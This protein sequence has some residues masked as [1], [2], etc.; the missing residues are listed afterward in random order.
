M[1]D[2]E[3]R[4]WQALK[5]VKFPGMSRDIVSFGFVEA[6]ATEGGRATVT[7]Q[8]TTHNEEAV[9]QVRDD[10]ERA[11]AGVD[12][13]ESAQV[14][15]K[16][17]RPPTPGGGAQRAVSQDAQL[18]SNV[19]HVVAV[20]SGKGGV[21]KSTVAANLAVS[22][23]KAG[24]RVG[25]L[26]ADIYGPSMPMMFGIT[27]RPRIEANRVIPFER[28]GVKVMSLGFVVDTDTP[29]IW[30]GPMVMKALEQLMGD[31]EWGELDYMIVDLPPGTGDAQLTITQK[32]PLSGAVVVTTPQDVALIDA[33]KGLA[34]FRKVNV[35]VVGIVEN[36][37]TFVCPHCGEATDV[38]KS[39]GGER[40]AELLG[41][42]FLG[43]IPLDPEIVAGGDEGKPIVVSR[44]EGSHAE[45]F[46]RVAEAVAEEAA[47]G[48]SER[49]KM[50]IV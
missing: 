32:V 34:M 31:V 3:E 40:T 39:G 35:P 8:M 38:F 1:A 11:V 21:G 28:Y 47:K 49:P 7:L 12:G 26:D 48:A 14:E 19:E 10:V 17:S 25:L 13:V 50:S 6:V 20:A 18:L 41:T 27:E 2:L 22:L 44:P 5:T 16:V 36:M 15:L 37:G 24:H 43:T 46:R 29:V 4:I 23:A 30:R 45:A 42:A 33:R 9:A